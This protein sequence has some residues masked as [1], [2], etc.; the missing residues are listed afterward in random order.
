MKTLPELFK[1]LK[2][3]KSQF[4]FFMFGTPTTLLECLN[5]GYLA[6]WI[7]SLKSDRIE[8][9][10][11][12]GAS[13]NAPFLVINPK[14]IWLFGI[15]LVIT[16]IGLVH[17]KRGSIVIRSL[18]LTLSSVIWIAIALN[19][20]ASY[21]K[22]HM[23]VFTYSILGGLSSLAGYYMYKYYRLANVLLQN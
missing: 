13:I 2:T 11:I 14:T 4:M 3:K 23:S 6:T 7:Y 19:V 20:N 16:L 18:G 1:F 22:I 21:E 5:L 8:S 9:I 15:A 12:F 10:I 17:T